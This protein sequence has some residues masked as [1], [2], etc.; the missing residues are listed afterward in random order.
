MLQA[1]AKWYAR[2]AGDT[3]T[4]I[5]TILCLYFSL[6]LCKSASLSPLEVMVVVVMVMLVIVLMIVMTLFTTIII[7]IILIS[8]I[9]TIIIT[10]VI[11]KEYMQIERQRD[12]L[13]N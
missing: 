7:T 1:F 13:R 10:I 12:N 11:I 8:I 3:T 4:T 9:I 2:A 6:S 5:T